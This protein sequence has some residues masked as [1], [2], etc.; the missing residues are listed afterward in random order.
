MIPVPFS[1]RQLAAFQRVYPDAHVRSID[2]QSLLVWTT[3]KGKRRRS[4]LIHMAAETQVEKRVRIRKS[5]LFLT[6][7]HKRATL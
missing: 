6:T 4:L 3:N 5:E 7:T 2:G 1:A